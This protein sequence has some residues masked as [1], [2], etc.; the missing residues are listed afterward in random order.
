MK[1]FPKQT[2]MFTLLGKQQLNR[3]VGHFIT[4]FTARNYHVIF[5]KVIRSPIE[6]VMYTML[7]CLHMCI[8]FRKTGNLIKIIINAI[9]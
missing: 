7:A 6:H 3:D 1:E 8:F 5:D 4:S 9:K 2:Y